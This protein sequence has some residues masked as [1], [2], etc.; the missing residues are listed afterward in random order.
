MKFRD[1][2]LGLTDEERAEYARRAGTSPL[3]MP[4]LVNERPFKVPKPDLIRG[5]AK[6]SDGNVS[7]HEVL[8][9]FYGTLPHEPMPIAEG[10]EHISEPIRR[11]RGG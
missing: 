11:S 2:Y 10:W 6:A 3:Y 9:H 5:L 1:Y 4:Q 8:E 7:L